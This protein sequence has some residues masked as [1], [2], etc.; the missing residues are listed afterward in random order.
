MAV[1]DAAKLLMQ[2]GQPAAALGA[3]IITPYDVVVKSL[4]KGYY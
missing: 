1:S 4:Q 3:S 2:V